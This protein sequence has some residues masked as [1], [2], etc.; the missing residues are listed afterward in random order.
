M[1]KSKAVYWKKLLTDYFKKYY[2]FDKIHFY[3]AIILCKTKNI[4]NVLQ[5]SAVEHWQNTL[6]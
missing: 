3:P 6:S 5:K 1:E 2:L 4:K